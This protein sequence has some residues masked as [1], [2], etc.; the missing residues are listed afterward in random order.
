MS[1]CENEKLVELVSQAEP[2]EETPF[3]IILKDEKIRRLPLRE[4]LKAL[5][6]GVGVEIKEKLNKPEE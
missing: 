4:K 6:K 5:L 3:L 1:A 2:I